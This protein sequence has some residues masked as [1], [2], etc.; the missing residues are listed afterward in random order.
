MTS[1]V[2]KVAGLAAAVIAMTLPHSALATGNFKFKNTGDFTGTG[3]LTVTS[4]A[5]SIPCQVS[6]SGTTEGPGAKITS[7]T[8]SGAT[9]L[10]VSPSGLPWSIHPQTIHSMLIKDVTISAAVLGI[11]GP[12]RLK[13]QITTQGKITISGSGLK[14]NLG[15]VPCSVSGTLQTR[16][17][18]E[19][20]G[21]K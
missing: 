3:S 12:G 17:H 14:S 21:R 5:V 16:P 13:A 15:V 11:C 6:L 4:V 7:A 10:A 1:K 9:C 2:L 20:V 8:F 19:I 18:L